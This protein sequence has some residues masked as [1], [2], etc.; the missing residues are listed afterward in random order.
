MAFSTYI[1]LCAKV[2]DNIY[3]LYCFS[4]LWFW[5]GRESHVQYR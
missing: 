4:V 1:D 2:K 3:M 5:G